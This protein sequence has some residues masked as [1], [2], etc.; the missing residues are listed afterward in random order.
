M[1]SSDS[2]NTC[3]SRNIVHINYKLTIGP[4]FTHESED[5][6]GLY[7]KFN[8]IVEIEGLLKVGRSHL[9]KSGTTQCSRICILCLFRFQKT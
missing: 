6:R 4:M 2:F 5:A 9:C 1:I 7:F 8:C 3:N